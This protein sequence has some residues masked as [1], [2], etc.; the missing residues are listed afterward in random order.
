M[1]RQRN[2]LKQVYRDLSVLVSRIVGESSLVKEAIG[3]LLTDASMN[4]LSVCISQIGMRE[5]KNAGSTSASIAGSGRLEGMVILKRRKKVAAKR[6]RHVWLRNWIRLIDFI[7][8]IYIY[9][10]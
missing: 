8:Y 2:A 5:L 3:K 1:P 6:R 9:I 10:T 7:F 4:V